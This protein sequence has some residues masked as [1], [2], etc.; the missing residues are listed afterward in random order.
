MRSQTRRGWGPEFKMLIPIIDYEPYI[1]GEVSKRIALALSIINTS[2]HRSGRWTAQ[3]K[4]TC[5]LDFIPCAIFS[6]RFRGDCDRAVAGSSLLPS[7]QATTGTNA[8][9]EKPSTTEGGMV[10]GISRGSYFH[11]RVSYRG[12]PFLLGMT[13]FSS[14]SIHRSDTDAR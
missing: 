14:S 4:S 13:S 6:I 8:G 1:I 5:S 7:G 11:R 2:V 12:E 3:T 9:P 10:C